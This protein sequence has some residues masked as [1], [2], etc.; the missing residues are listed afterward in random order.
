MSDE[1]VAHSTGAA[2]YSA[3]QSSDVTGGP[4]SLRA[5]RSNF[6]SA[7]SQQ[8]A[9]A[10][11]FGPDSTGTAMR[12]SIASPLDCGDS[13]K[14]LE[15]LWWAFIT[16][17]VYTVPL[18]IALTRFPRDVSASFHYL[19]LA[20]NWLFHAPFYGAVFVFYQAVAVVG[21]TSPIFRNIF[22][23]GAVCAYAALAV[24]LV[25]AVSK[26]LKVRW[27]TVIG[28]ACGAPF[29]LQFAW[30]LTLGVLSFGQQMMH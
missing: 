20:Y 1:Q 18:G 22:G 11:Q 15:F 4:C 14:V 6:P 13:P 21:G 5:F 17:F 27:V 7:Y 16:G 9:P 24:L 10:G 30:I 8:T 12:H 2:I 3:K 26:A 19:G 23:A 28:G 29:A 25:W